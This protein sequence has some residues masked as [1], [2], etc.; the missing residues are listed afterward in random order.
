MKRFSIVLFVL[1]MTALIGAWG[2]F[3]PAVNPGAQKHFYIH[4]GS[5]WVAV[6]DSLISQHIISN[7]FWF[8]LLSKASRYD[9]R[10]RPGRYDI[11]EAKNIFR[12]VRKL[13]SGIQD[14]VRLTITKIRTRAELAGKIARKLECDSTRFINFL[15]S[16]DSLTYIQEDTNT[17]LTIIIPN[18]YL[19]FWDANVKAILNTL[20][21]QKL[22]FWN[23]KRKKLAAEHG[24]T[25]LQV[26]TLASIVEEETNEEED[27]GLIASVYLNRLALGMKLEADPTARFALGDFSIKRVLSDHLRITSPYNTYLN[28]GLPPGPICTPSI[29]TIDAVLHAPKTDFLF[30]VASPDFNGRSVFS[31]DYA[32]H[33]KNAVIYRKALDSLLGSQKNNR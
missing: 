7:G 15:N 22:S 28:K 31:K 6:R 13:R 26:Y 27:K 4:S 20:V 16:N 14:P 33:L 5:G 24:L 29:R 2:F 12:L 32:G 18:T 21:S 3:G 9:T 25:P 19:I 8:T 30:F 11:S 10:V 23:E 1:F 17:V